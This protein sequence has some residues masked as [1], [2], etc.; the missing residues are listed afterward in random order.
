MS[1]E[2]PGASDDGQPGSAALA[3][4]SDALEVAE[5]RYREARNEL[6]PVLGVGGMYSVEELS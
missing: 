2:R 6:A 5:D 1:D 4:A 3:E